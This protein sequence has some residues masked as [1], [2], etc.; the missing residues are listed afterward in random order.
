MH[1]TKQIAGSFAA[2]DDAGKEIVCRVIQHIDRV[3]TLDFVPGEWTE[4]LL[5]REIETEYGERV[6]FDP[7]SRSLT[8]LGAIPSAL[9]FTRVISGELGFLQPTPHE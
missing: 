1:S 4:V 2:V 9:R 6:Q 3:Q 7:A 8:L 5:L